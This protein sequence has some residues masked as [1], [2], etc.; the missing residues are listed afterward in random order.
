MDNDDIDIVITKFE[1]YCVGERNET[2]ERY[3]FNMRVQQ[4]ESTT[5]G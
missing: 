3:N 1:E 5:R 4:Y 2:L